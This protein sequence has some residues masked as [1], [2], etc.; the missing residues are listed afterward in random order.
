MTNVESSFVFV[1]C[2]KNKFV[3]QPH[4][5]II[6]EKTHLVVLNSILLVEL[7]RMINSLEWINQTQLLSDEQM[8]HFCGQLS[9]TMTTFGQILQCRLKNKMT[10][11]NIVKLLTKLYTIL[12]NLTRQVIRFL[13]S[14]IEGKELLS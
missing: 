7:E 8:T 5:L 14:S 13:L 2:S 11:I 10:I 1:S 3:H 6:N 12:E 4:F 9:F